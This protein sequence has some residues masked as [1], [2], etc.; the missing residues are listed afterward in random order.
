MKIRNVKKEKGSITLYVLVSMIFFVILLM[1]IYIRSSNKIQK[2]QADEKKIQTE[3]TLENVDDIY[4]ETVD[5][6]ADS[7]IRTPTI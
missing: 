7:D 5:K 4:N 3:Y 6:K 2:Q 1:G